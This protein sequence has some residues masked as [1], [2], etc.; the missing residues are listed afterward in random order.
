M[1][2]TERERFR[3][4]PASGSSEARLRPVSVA[5]DLMMSFVEVL[6][7]TSALIGEHCANDNLTSA[8]RLSVHHL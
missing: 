7:F 6:W 2:E 3:G 4:G 1:E 8:Q 5:L